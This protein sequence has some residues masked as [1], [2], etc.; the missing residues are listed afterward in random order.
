MHIAV[1]G[2]RFDPPHRGHLW[3]ARQVKDYVP[4]I[5]RVLLV[6]AATHQ[7][8]KT[9]ATAEDRLAMVKL[10]SGN[11]IESSD[12]ELRRGGISYSIDTIKALKEETGAEISWIVG[13]DILQEFEKWEKSDK[14]LSEA[15]FLIFPRDPYRLPE[16]IPQGFQVIQNDNLLVSNLSSTAIKERIKNKLSIRDFV[17]ESV[18]TYIKD[19]SLYGYDKY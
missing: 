4:G 8:K 6:P 1:L 11:G 2:G 12:I 9:E 7:W 19:N 3:V 5:E 16:R 18:E 14:L 15:K 17:T 10:M 13:S